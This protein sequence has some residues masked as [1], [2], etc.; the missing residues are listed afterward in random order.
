[1]ADRTVRHS[2]FID[3]ESAV[4]QLPLPW[5]KLRYQSIDSRTCVASFPDLNEEETDIIIAELL[6]AL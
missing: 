3:L 5:P 2:Q 4:Q 6:M 1:M